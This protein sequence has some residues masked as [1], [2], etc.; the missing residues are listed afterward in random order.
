VLFPE[1]AITV[2]I[3]TASRDELSRRVERREVGSDRGS[4]QERTDRQAR[5]IA[6]ELAGGRVVDT[7]GRGVAEVAGTLLRLAA[8]NHASVEGAATPGLE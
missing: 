6:G 4:Q 7:E 3:L 5:E 8:W 2:V 1:A